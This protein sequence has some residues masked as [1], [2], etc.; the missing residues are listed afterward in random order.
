[1]ERARMARQEV[2]GN[3]D[4]IQ[5]SKDRETRARLEQ[6]RL[7]KVI[8]DREN[9]ETTNPD[10][11]MKPRHYQPKKEP[12]EPLEFD[13]SY[14]PRDEQGARNIVKSTLYDDYMRQANFDTMK[15]QRNNEQD[16]EQVHRQINLRQQ[17]HGLLVTCFSCATPGHVG[18]LCTKLNRHP[19]FKEMSP[20]VVYPH[21]KIQYIPTE[22][23]AEVQDCATSPI[24]PKERTLDENKLL[25]ETQ[26]RGYPTIAQTILIETIK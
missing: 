14:K 9:F 4:K 23:H 15:E 19:L 25:R 2:K 17:A 16:R 1:M 26:A 3:L 21:E 18:V 6:E 24:F 22:E 11:E 10:K 20:N 5:I 7:L 13:P 8:E 12:S